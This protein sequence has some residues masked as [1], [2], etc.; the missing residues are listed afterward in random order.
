MGLGA[1]ASGTPTAAESDNDAEPSADPGGDA[2]GHA[3]TCSSG[4]DRS[5]CT[6]DSGSL[7]A[8]FP[9][10][11]RFALAA[12][13]SE[14][15]VEAETSGAGMGRP[16]PLGPA[17]AKSFT[18]W[19]P[20]TAVAPANCNNA[21]DSAARGPLPTMSPTEISFVIL[22]GSDAATVSASSS[23]AHLHN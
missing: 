23:A 21:T 19:L 6:W 7:R 1:A 22:P 16:P 14:C 12:S 18:S 20:R 13:S 15:T 5:H 10:L 2:E 4:R 9:A 11:K 3:S 17:L 8:S